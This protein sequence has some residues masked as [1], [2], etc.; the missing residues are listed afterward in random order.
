MPLQ[1]DTDTNKVV[2]LRAMGAEVA[3]FQRLV[4]EFCLL[5]FLFDQFSRSQP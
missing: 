5:W 2:Q 1:L 3:V 4:V